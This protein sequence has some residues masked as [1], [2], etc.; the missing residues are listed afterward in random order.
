VR[1][2]EIIYPYPGILGD[3]GRK[4]RIASCAHGE[5]GVPC[6]PKKISVHQESILAQRKDRRKK[7]KFLGHGR[8]G[9]FGGEGGRM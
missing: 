1:W 3:R 4:N 2:G 5:K 7:G 9:G 8:K 6:P